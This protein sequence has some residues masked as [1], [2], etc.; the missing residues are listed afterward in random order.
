MLSLGATNGSVIHQTD[1][2]NAYLYG[3]KLEE[4][5]YMELP[6]GYAE[7]R[8][9]II[10]MQRNSKR[11]L[12]TQVILPL[13]GSK[14][15]GR[16][17]R[18]RCTR[19]FLSMDYKVLEADHGVFYKVDVANG[20]YVIVATAVDDFTI[21]ADSTA[22]V[23]K[24]KADLAD[25]FELVDGGDLSWMLGITVNRDL[26]NKTVSLGQRAYIEEILK[27]AGLEHNTDLV[28]TPMDP[29]VNFADTSVSCH[30]LSPREKLLFR[31]LIGCLMYLM[32]ATRL[33]IAFAVSLLARFVENPRTTHMKALK[34][35]YKYVQATKHYQLVLG[36]K[37]AVLTGYT[38]ADWASQ[39]DRY[40][41]SGFTFSIGMGSFSWSSKKQNLIATST[42]E[43]EFTALAHAIKE[44]LWITKLLFEIPKSITHY[45]RGNVLEIKC[46]NKAAIILAKDP[47]YHARTKHFDV[48]LMFI[49]HHITAG[50]IIVQHCKS[51]DNVA[52]IFTKPLAVT[53]FE[54]FRTLLGV[55]PTARPA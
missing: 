54:K 28:D 43:S 12:I 35:V 25:D 4:V 1:V 40:S 52:D 29:G 31:I 7:F 50:E 42:S 36:G 55:L 44:L 2:K 49:R 3:E 48:S 8:P 53:K 21:I 33:D 16:N 18:K 13:Y 38:D 15:G 41:I 24:L 30:F 45:E 22:S 14:Q 46:D 11:R 51:E 37:E 10:E 9:E 27:R 20:T 23:E 6:E 34:R 5:I 47:S 17:W 39:P 32:V 19:K 26:E